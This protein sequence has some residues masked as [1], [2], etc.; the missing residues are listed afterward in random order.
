MDSIAEFTVDQLA[1]PAVQVKT[2]SVETYGAGLEA[3]LASPSKGPTEV[4][5]QFFAFARS[6]NDEDS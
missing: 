1:G 2:M 3:K 6:P 4:Q 5:I